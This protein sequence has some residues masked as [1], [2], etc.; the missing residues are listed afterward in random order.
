MSATTEN[1]AI[2][3]SQTRYFCLTTYT[4]NNALKSLKC[5]IHTLPEKK[6]HPSG[7]SLLMLLNYLTDN[8]H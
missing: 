6:I 5:P 7:F 3:V 8:D 4:D 2:H 1:F